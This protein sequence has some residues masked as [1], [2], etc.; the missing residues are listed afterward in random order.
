LDVLVRV[1]PAN[2]DLSVARDADSCLHA[3]KEAERAF[4]AKQYAMARDHYS[5][6]LRIAESSTY[7]M[8]QRAFC[9]FY[10]VESYEAIADTGKVLKIEADHLGALELRGKSYY[11]L[12]EMDMAMNHF[13]KGLK[14]DPEHEG[15]KGGYRLVKKLQT[16]AGKGEQ[17]MSSGDYSGAIKHLLSLIEVDPQHRTVM[18]QAYYS[19]ARANKELKN[20]ESMVK[21]AGLALEIADNY[22]EMHHLLGQGYMDQEKWD[23]AIASLRR[24]AE[25]ADHHDIGED[26]RRAE[27]ALKQSKQK[28]YYKALGLS[29]R[30]KP[31]EIKKAY[32]EKALQWHPDKHS[33][34]VEKAAAEKEFQ[35]VAEA[36]EVLSDP[37]TRGKYDRGEE[38]FP[39]QGGGGQQRN[40]FEHF[41][42]GFP[43]GGGGNFH[44]RFG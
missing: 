3:G 35:A 18:P 21:F 40:P 10:L 14:S 23:E 7:H 39:N 26:L 38:V 16:L 20:Y 31:K 42:S 6:V 5:S 33:G 19:L 1:N 4:N 13:R 24:A 30:A 12:G 9:H 22:W 29:R 36:Y 34:E 8:L 2:K 28:D 32:R 37:E 25:L 17:A 11:A 44:F 43:G 41:Q 27:A 15:C